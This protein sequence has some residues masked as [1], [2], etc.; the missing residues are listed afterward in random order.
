MIAG[1]YGIPHT[2][3]LP[4]DPELANC[5]DSGIIEL[6]KENPLEGFLSDILG[7]LK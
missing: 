3:E 1:E 7:E 2:A 5:V 4:V 6:Y